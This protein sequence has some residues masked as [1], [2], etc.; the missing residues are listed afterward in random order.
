MQGPARKKLLNG[1]VASAASGLSAY[2]YANTNMIDNNTDQPLAE[3]VEVVAL[4]DI[5]GNQEWDK[6]KISSIKEIIHSFDTQYL[7]DFWRYGCFLYP[8]RAEELCHEL[9]IEFDQRK[10]EFQE[11]C[12]KVFYSVHVIEEF[13]ALSEQQADDILNKKMIYVSLVNPARDDREVVV[14]YFKSSATGGLERRIVDWRE[15]RDLCIYSFH[16]L[17][18]PSQGALKASLSRIDQLNLLD[19]VS[20]Y[21]GETVINSIE[22]LEGFRFQTAEAINYVTNTL[23]DNNCI[24]RFQALRSLMQF[25]PTHVSKLLEKCA[26]QGRMQML[27]AIHHAYSNTASKVGGAVLDALNHQDPFLIEKLGRE[28]KKLGGLD[29]LGASF[30][31]KILSDRYGYISQHQEENQRAVEI[32]NLS[33]FEGALFD[34]YDSIQHRLSLKAA[35]QVDHTC[36]ISSDAEFKTLYLTRKPLE[37][38]QESLIKNQQAVYVNFDNGDW[39]IH[40]AIND[41]LLSVV[42]DKSSILVRELESAQEGLTDDIIY[43]LVRKYL[44]EHD[45]YDSYAADT[46]FECFLDAC[47]EEYQAKQ[48]IELCR[49]FIIHGSHYVGG[50]VSFDKNGK[51]IIIYLD[52]MGGVG[53][54]LPIRLS[55]YFTKKG[56][57]FEFYASSNYQQYG[58]V[59]CSFFS[60]NFIS[61]LPLIDF[62]V[63]K[64]WHIKDP[65]CSPFVD[66]LRSHVQEEYEGVKNC[67]SPLALALMTQ[68]LRVEKRKSGNLSKQ[69][70]NFLITNHATYAAEYH[71]AANIQGDTCQD[72]IT[73]NSISKDGKMQNYFLNSFFSEL[74]REA[75]RAALKMPGNDLSNEMLKRQFKS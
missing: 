32:S 21:G 19:A 73:R 38:D 69:G 15:F 35:N 43:Y 36:L 2:T 5:I 30:L 45:I 70:L 44:M 25:S 74:S 22:P 4:M 3:S 20:S 12:T 11:S 1:L 24:S 51:P 8:H 53:F 27:R 49:N 54:D 59:G 33:G 60:L 17:S 57:D 62:L 63:S 10:R 64:F 31:L 58:D 18:M 50:R 9:A 75:I 66:Y 16:Q 65:N 55:N 71:S 26:D 67:L 61:T 56:L 46:R 29:A 48:S 13:R 47:I 72:I 52:S 7:E 68:S 41:S 34:Y 23:I 39:K 42:I 14:L 37:A 40:T 28:L 6:L